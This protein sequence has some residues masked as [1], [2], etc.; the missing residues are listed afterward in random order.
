MKLTPAQ[1]QKR[2]QDNEKKKEYLQ[3]YKKYKQKVKRLEEQLAEVRSGKMSP[4][5]IQSDMP[6]AHNQKDLSDYIVQ[7]DKIIY[8][9][10]KA[11]RDA[12]VRFSEVQQQIE[13]LEDE[14]EKTVLT[15]R[16]L[17]DY[18]WEKICVEMQYSWKQIHRIHSRALQNFELKD[19]IE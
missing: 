17:R 15:L 6:S 16:Y 1:R 2:Q 18:N 12:V 10:I 11:Q 5:L 3:S 14:N 19:D 13:F 7:C 9:I 4:S 8:E